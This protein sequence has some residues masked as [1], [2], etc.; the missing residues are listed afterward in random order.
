MAAI[1]LQTSHSRGSLAILIALVVGA[2]VASAAAGLFLSES[3]HQRFVYKRM[4]ALESFYTNEAAQWM[5]YEAVVSGANAGNAGKYPANLETDYKTVADGV[6]AGS[7]QSPPNL[8]V[9]RAFDTG[10]ALNQ[11]FRPG[12]LVFEIVPK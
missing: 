1:P 3:W 9:T 2:V 4:G 11:R 8:S 12:R 10:P 7:G 6:P 5:G